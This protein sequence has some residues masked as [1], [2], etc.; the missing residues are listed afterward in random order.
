MRNGQRSIVVCER[1]LSP[2]TWQHALA[3]TFK[4]PAPPPLIVSSRLADDFLWAEAL[5]LGVYDVLAKPFNAQ[6]VVRV[7]HLA[8]S[9]REFQSQRTMV[10]TIAA[11]G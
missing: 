9:H 6:E 3:E 2:G 10:T 4:L 11:A 8:W 1:D 7:L 5:N